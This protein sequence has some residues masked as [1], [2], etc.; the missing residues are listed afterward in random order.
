[1]L[2]AIIKCKVQLSK[3][4]E[5]IKIVYREEFVKSVSKLFETETQAYRRREKAEEL[6]N[7]YF[8]DLFDDL[9]DESEAVESLDLDFD[10]IKLHG[11]ELGFE[12]VP[13]AIEV[14]TNTEDPDSKDLLDRLEDD[15]SDF[16]SSKLNRELS[17]ELLD[18]YL[19][20]AFAE[21][22]RSKLKT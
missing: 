8:G 5:M 19:K 3:Y 13:G 7:E 9:Y 12:F 11:T 10:K 16:V 14:Y 4:G 20:L 15:G 21:T 1:V 2:Q 18:Q 6:I 17:D 22:L